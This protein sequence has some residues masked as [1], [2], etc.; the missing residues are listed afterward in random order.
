MPFHLNAKLINIDKIREN[1]F[2]FSIEAK[3]IAET[4]KSGQ[5][6]EIRVSDEIEPL[7]R[8][9]ISI[10][11]IR[12]DENIVE[13]IFEV[14]GKGTKILSQKQIGDKIDVIGPLG[15][16]TFNTENIKNAVII[17]G[18][19]GSFP[20]YNLAKE[21]K[22]IAN[23]NIYLGF[24]NKDVVV[25]EKEF[26]EVCNKLKITTDDGSYGIKGFAINVLE[27]DLKKQEK[28]DIIYACGPLPMLKRVQ[29]L[30]KSLNIPCQ[31][32][33]EEKMACGMG[34]CL[35]CAVK[36]SNS[37]K[38]NPEYMHVCKAGPVFWSEDVEI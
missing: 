9:P 8:R 29:E 20:L 4:A 10:F 36:T 37:S 15:Y 25:L 18:G 7:L 16:G 30:A 3:E 34:V 26:E 31:I 19:I 23:T 28:P 2:K 5:F 35:G 32:S 1:L 27:E 12:K 14:R 13:F 33:L 11:N 21:L 22:N 38:E 6:I 24:K 17:A